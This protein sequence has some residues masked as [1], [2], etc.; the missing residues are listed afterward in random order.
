LT[1]DVRLAKLWRVEQSENSSQYV[2]ECGGDD[3]VLRSLISCPTLP[4]DVDQP[5]AEI[6]GRAQQAARASS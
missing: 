1:R 5:L 2:A 6:L 3:V 4:P